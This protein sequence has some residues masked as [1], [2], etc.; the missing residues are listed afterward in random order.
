MSTYRTLIVDDERPAR[1]KLRRLLA[2]DARFSVVGEAASGLEALELIENLCPDL[3]I[4]D[5]QMPGATGFE[6]LESIGS[7]REFSVIFSTAHEQH[8]LRAFDADAMDYLLKPYDSERLAKALNKAHAELRGRLLGA[9]STL[10]SSLARQQDRLIFKTSKGWIPIRLRDILRISAAGKHVCL[11]TR[12]GAEHVVRASLRELEARLDPERFVQV[13]RSDIVPLDAV[14]KL[15]A[16]THGD[17]LLELT[18]GST[19]ILTRTYRAQFLRLFR[20]G[21]TGAGA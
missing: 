7:Q 6:V 18:D 4:L 1:A 19:L 10:L 12:G 14:A 15:R 13:H 11:V 3:V 16:W 21:S 9:T 8:A 5:I 20:R 2:N 17:A